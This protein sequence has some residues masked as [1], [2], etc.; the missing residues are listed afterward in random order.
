M[1]QSVE[2]DGLVSPMESARAE[3]DDAGLQSL[4]ISRGRQ[5]LD[6]VFESKAA[7]LDWFRVSRKRWQGF[8]RRLFLP[9]CPALTA[10]DGKA[11]ST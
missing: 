4:A 8:I 1:Q 7:G 5:R 9:G 11:A 2:I 6:S 10:L 3:V